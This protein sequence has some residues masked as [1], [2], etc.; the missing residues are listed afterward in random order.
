VEN[1]I[2][3]FQRLP[4]FHK[5]KFWTEDPQGRENATETLDVA[6]CHS[7]RQS[8]SGSKWMAARFDMVLVDLGSGDLSGIEGSIVLIFCICCDS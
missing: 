4:L 5:I 3:P 2:L 6:H 7:R 8:K 1:T